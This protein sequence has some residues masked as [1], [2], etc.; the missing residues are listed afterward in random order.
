MPTDEW[1]KA[2]QRR[3]Y[4]PANPGVSLGPRREKTHKKRPMKTKH[5]WVSI[6]V[7]AILTVTKM[8]IEVHAQNGR[9]AW[10]PRSAMMNG[11]SKIKVGQVFEIQCD[12]W[13]AVRERVL[14]PAKPVKEDRPYKTEADF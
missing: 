9:T 12:K 6:G 8:A 7:C 4:G 5:T 14:P 1:K 11:N 13:L 3:K 2:T 10:L